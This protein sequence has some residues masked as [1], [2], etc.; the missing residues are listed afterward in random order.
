MVREAAAPSPGRGLL[1]IRASRSDT[2]A[3]SGVLL[4]LESRRVSHMLWLDGVYENVDGDGWACEVLHFSA[5]WVPLS[6][7]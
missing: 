1:V 2:V 7:V 5:Q 6:K 3:N 4:H